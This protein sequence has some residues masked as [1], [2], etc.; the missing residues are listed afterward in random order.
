AAEVSVQLIAVPFQDG[1]DLSAIELVARVER[2]KHG[3]GEG[4]CDFLSA[5]AAHGIRNRRGGPAD[6]V[7]V[8]VDAH[9]AEA[10]E[11]VGPVAAVAAQVEASVRVHAPDVVPR[12]RGG[13]AGQPVHWRADRLPRDGVLD[14]DAGERDQQTVLRTGDQ[15]DVGGTK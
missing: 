13:T 12:C 7:Q 8:V 2:V 5:E 1:A 9:V 15:A 10:D 11:H 3:G 14:H 6:H 4:R